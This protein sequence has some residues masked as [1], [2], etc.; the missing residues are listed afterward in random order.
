MATVGESSSV[1]ARVGDERV[2]PPTTLIR[3]CR[4]TVSLSVSRAESVTREPAPVVLVVGVPVISRVWKLRARP[5][6]RF[7]AV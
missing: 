2:T 7:V 6:G 1:M 3:N 5:A 4:V